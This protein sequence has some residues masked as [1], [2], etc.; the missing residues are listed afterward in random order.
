MAQLKTDGMNPVPGLAAARAFWPI[1]E[2]AVCTEDPARY[3]Q[4]VA[5]IGLWANRG[6]KG[7]PKPTCCNWYCRSAAAQ[8]VRTTPNSFR[9]GSNVGGCTQEPNYLTMG[10]TDLKKQIFSP[11]RQ[12]GAL[13]SMQ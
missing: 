2:A 8:R 6:G 3:R 5:G 11:F 7:A 1:S 12:E 9:K 10:L 13:L 4:P